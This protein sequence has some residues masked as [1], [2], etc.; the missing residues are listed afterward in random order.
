MMTP[1]FELQQYKK[2]RFKK[3]V[4]SFNN[5]TS[6]RSFY[7]SFFHFL[8][9]SLSLSLSLF[10]SLFTHQTYIDIKRGGDVS[11]PS[12]FQHFIRFY[13]LILAC[14][15]S[16]TVVKSFDIVVVYV[17]GLNCFG[18]ERKSHKLEQLFLQDFFHY[19]HDI[20]FVKLEILNI[21]RNQAM[22]I[23]KI[24]VFINQS[25]RWLEEVFM[26]W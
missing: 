15:Q 8:S 14:V 16:L 25:N 11:Y 26:V 22:V 10:L 4:A 12:F 2:N 7:I 1:H 9:L 21:G 18:G 17:R 20:S 5:P 13:L 23:T 3:V 24:L 19:N 6:G